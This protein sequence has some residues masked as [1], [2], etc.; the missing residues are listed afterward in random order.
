MMVVRFRASPTVSAV[1]GCPTQG[2]LS[3][4]R[5]LWRLKA[6]AT[7]S[8]L[9][10]LLCAM[11]VRDATAQTYPNGANAC[12]VVTSTWS[13]G[14][15]FLYTI[16]G[17]TDAGT[18]GSTSFWIDMT[19]TGAGSRVANLLAAA[20]AG[21]SLCVWNY[22]QTDDYGGQAAYIAIIEEVSW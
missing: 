9:A 13:F 20:A 5:P 16:Q 15:M 10:C 1:A 4:S 11:P 2:I 18:S 3:G 17:T 6:L 14:T 21:R 19:G 12:G 22:G 8:V 7:T